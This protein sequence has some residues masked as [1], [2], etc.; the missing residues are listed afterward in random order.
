MN[1]KQSS[2]LLP[3]IILL[4]SSCISIKNTPQ[5]NSE[6]L[7]NL[8][9]PEYDIK[10]IRQ[11]EHKGDRT[12]SQGF[13]IYNNILFESTGTFDKSALKKINIDTGEI[14]LQKNLE[15]YFPKKDVFAE[16]L[17]I[18]DNKIIQLSWLNKKAFLYNLDF[19][20]FEEEFRYKEE[21]WGLTNNGK[22]FIMSDGSNILYFRDINTF[23]IIKK[24]KIKIYDLNELEYVDG[25][26]YANVF[27]ENFIV[28]IDEKSGSITGK[29]NTDKLSEI[30]LA[31]DD[32]NK[33]LNG[34]AYNIETKTFFI[35]GKEWPFIYEVIFIEKAI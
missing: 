9:I 7:K 2:L 15:D 32:E 4:I 25:T 5:D 26:I 21:G 13:E 10:I 22:Y 19:E 3:N 16:G 33:V 6:I 17:T 12:F 24:L 34:I 8:S 30:K 28:M 29:I 14:L 11:I 18:I 20:K 35:T 31:E 23:N 1:I 27:G